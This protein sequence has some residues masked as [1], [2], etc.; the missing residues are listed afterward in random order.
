MRITY[1]VVVVISN[2][3]IW[4]Q[5]AVLMPVIAAFFTILL[6]LQDPKT[7]PSERDRRFLLST[8]VVVAIVS[9][10]LGIIT[11]LAIYVSPDLPM[12]LPDH[13]LPR[14]L[15]IDFTE[16]GYSRA[17]ALD[18]LNLGYMWQCR[19]PARIHGLRRGR[20]PDCGHLPH[21]GRG[22]QSPTAFPS[23]SLHQASQADTDLLPG[24]G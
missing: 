3:S 21:G 18:R 8:I 10:T 20:Q 14:S 7:N 9:T 5:F 23:G 12:V 6:V 13:N 15:E 2:A 16:L 22:G 4:I 19:V 17:E 11:I 1:A 24:L